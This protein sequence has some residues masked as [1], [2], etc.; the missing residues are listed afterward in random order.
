MVRIGVVDSGVNPSELKYAQ[1]V[2]W[3]DFINGVSTPYCNSG[4]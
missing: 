4:G 1:V 2:G 3:K